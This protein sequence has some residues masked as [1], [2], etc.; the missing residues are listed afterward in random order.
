MEYSIEQIEAAI[1]KTS[2]DAHWNLSIEDIQPIIAEL[3]KP[4]WIPQV[5]EVYNYGGGEY[6]KRIQ[7]HVNPRKAKPLIPDEVPGWARDKAALKVAIKGLNIALEDVLDYVVPI[8]Q[9]TRLR[10]SLDKI[11]ELTG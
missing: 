10:E 2:I 11:K 9:K 1:L 3:T 7:D 5:G 6:L 8:G 4:K